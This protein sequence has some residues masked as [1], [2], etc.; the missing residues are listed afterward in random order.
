MAIAFALSACKQ[1][2]TRPYVPPTPPPT[3][4]CDQTQPAATLPPLPPITTPPAL[5]LA[6]MDRWAIAAMGVFA[7]EVTIRQSEH[8]CMRT[9]RQKGV[10]R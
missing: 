1:N 10:I 3:V 2:S 9:L 8:A 5:M 4:T 7:G 6:A